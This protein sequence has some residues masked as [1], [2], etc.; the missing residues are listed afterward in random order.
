[1]NDK[2]VPAGP[3]ARYEAALAEGR[4]L[5]QKCRDCGRHV[6]YPRAFCTHCSS[7]ALDW[8]AP[9][10]EGTVYSTTVVRRKRE[11]GGDY[12]VSLIDLDEGV[13]LMSRVEGLPPDEVKIGMRVRA[14]IVRK[15][16]QPLLVFHAAAAKEAS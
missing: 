2:S 8:V 1:M 11:A 16:E 5:I 14:A 6:F 7:E 3:Q 13:R 4:F 9:S 15:G 12:G 10:G